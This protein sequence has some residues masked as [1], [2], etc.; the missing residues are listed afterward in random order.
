MYRYCR[1]LVPHLR[2]ETRLPLRAIPLLALGLCLG[3]EPAVLAKEANRTICCR[4]SGGTRGT[5]LNLWVHLVPP[6]NRFNP[7]SS[8]LIAM[9]QGPSAQ[10]TAMVLQLSNL[11]G[12]PV[13]GQMLPAQ[14]VGV[15]LLK[16]PAADRPALNQPLVWESFP[17]CQPNKPPTRSIL[18]AEPLQDPSSSPGPKD[19]SYQA[20]LTDRS[21][22]ALA[23][24]RKACG[25]M[26]DTKSLLDAFGFQVDEWSAK[27]PPQ[28]PVYCE[29]L[30]VQ[31]LGIR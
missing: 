13:G 28:L 20:P 17:T 5:C 9:L 16:L 18:V 31:S 7:G 30:S 14:G 1:R 24:L 25:G 8:R 6:S 27:L 15:R 29:T 12:D 3:F 26:A 11:A 21:Q 4:S 23:A 2:S 19:V 10:P 22:N